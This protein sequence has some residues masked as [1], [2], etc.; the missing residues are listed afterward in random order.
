VSDGKSEQRHLHDAD[1]DSSQADRLLVALPLDSRTVSP[2]VEIFRLIPV[3][4]YLV[5]KYSARKPHPK[6]VETPRLPL[7]RRSRRLHEIAAAGDRRFWE[8]HLGLASGE[9]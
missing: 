6:R 2:L 3:L 1:H 4:F 5:E 7:A 8:L 9:S